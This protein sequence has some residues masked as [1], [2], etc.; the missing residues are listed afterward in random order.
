LL[1][2]Q[3]RCGVDECA[4]CVG[5][6]DPVDLHYVAPRKIER[7]VHDRVVAVN[8]PTDLPWNRDVQVFCLAPVEPEQ[9]R[10]GRVRDRRS[11]TSPSFMILLPSVLA[12]RWRTK[13]RG[14]GPEK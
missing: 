13:R 6:L 10:G 14:E 7:S 9:R 11:R 2:V 3:Q 4:R 8:P 5:G 12:G 1:R